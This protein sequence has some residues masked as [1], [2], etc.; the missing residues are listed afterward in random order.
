MLPSVE[1]VLITFLSAVYEFVIFPRVWL[2]LCGNIM[3]LLV[4]TN[5]MNEEWYVSVF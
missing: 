1:S 4:F 2:T 5:L 3:S